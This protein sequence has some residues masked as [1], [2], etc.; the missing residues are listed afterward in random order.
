MSGFKKHKQQKK[1][2]IFYSNSKLHN[3]PLK[4]LNFENPY[5]LSL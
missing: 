3:I 5:L 1:K 2:F 4:G